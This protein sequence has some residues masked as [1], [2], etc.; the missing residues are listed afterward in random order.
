MGDLDD[1]FI[2]EAELDV[3][4]FSSAPPCAV[5]TEKLLGG[6][7]LLLPVFTLEFILS[8]LDYRLEAV[9]GAEICFVRLIV[10]CKFFA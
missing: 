7:L 3:L 6:L 1:L 2:P 8:W 5:L 4:L 10:G 9:P